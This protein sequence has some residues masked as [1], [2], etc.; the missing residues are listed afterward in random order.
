MQQSLQNWKHTVAAFI[1]AARASRAD[2]AHRTRALRGANACTGVIADFKSVS[3][4]NS[5]NIQALT[6]ICL[7]LMTILKKQ[8]LLFLWYLEVQ[9]LRE[10]LV[11]MQSKGGREQGA[12]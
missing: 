2:G 5:L 12:V 6:K 4:L 1:P 9:S 3:V 11:L 7:A 8:P 10:S